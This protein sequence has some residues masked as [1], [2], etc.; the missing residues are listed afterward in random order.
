VRRVC[1]LV[2]MLHPKL[3]ELIGKILGKKWPPEEISL[4]HSSRSAEEA[5]VINEKLG[6]KAELIEVEPKEWAKEALNYEEIV[7]LAEIP[8]G[9]LIKLIEKGHQKINVLVWQACKVHGKS[10]RRENIKLEVVGV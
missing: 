5:R 1:V 2:P 3:A 6:R 10:E 9:E 7:V 4:L 8:K